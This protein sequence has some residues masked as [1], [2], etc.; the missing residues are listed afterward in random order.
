VSSTEKASGESERRGMAVNDDGGSFY[1]LVIGGERTFSS[2]LVEG[3]EGWRPEGG[4]GV[5]FWKLVLM[6]NKRAK[7]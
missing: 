1:E 5:A 6:G 4:A 3:K 2:F 7:I